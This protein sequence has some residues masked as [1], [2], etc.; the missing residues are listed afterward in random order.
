MCRVRLALAL[1]LLVLLAAGLGQAPR[2]G[3]AQGTPAAEGGGLVVGP[4]LA[5]LPAADDGSA[6]AA[7][8]L[9]GDHALVLARNGLAEPAVLRV[10]A[11]GLDGAG[12]LAWVA[13]A[14]STSWANGEIDEG[15]QPGFVPAGGV[16]MAV[17]ALPAEAPAAAT[18]KY[19]AVAVPEDPFFAD[20]EKDL[21]V[22]SARLDGD[23][24]VVEVRNLGAEVR[25]SAYLVAFCL[26]PGGA[27][28][29]LASHQA[30]VALLEGEAATVEL[31][32]GGQPCDGFV[33]SARDSF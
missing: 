18:V 31:P 24:I 19:R 9:V 28:V 22:A 25:D 5:L 33:V 12:E 32:L 15:V 7:A 29:G 20:P 4:G 30:D 11:A 13:E 27:I 17:L 6:V 21:A 23:R 10:M 16:A 3:A 1:A 26:E 14:D 2:R 8:G